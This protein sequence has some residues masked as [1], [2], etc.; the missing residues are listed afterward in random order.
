M[1]RSR[2]AGLLVSSLAVLFGVT[3][4]GKGVTS[5]APPSGI[6]APVPPAGQDERLTDPASSWSP[7]LDVKNGGPALYPLDIGNRWVHEQHLVEVLIPRGGDPQL[8][9]EQR[10]SLVRGIV[11]EEAI[12]GRTYR[13]EQQATLDSA[14]V[15]FSWVRMRQDARG[16]Y[17]A[18][19]AT[20]VPPPCYRTPLDANTHADPVVTA[21]AAFE[22]V[23]ERAGSAATRSA[24]QAAWQRQQLK[25]GAARA[26]LAGG[27]TPESFRRGTRLP[28]EGELL[29]LAAPLRPGGS[30]VVR[31]DPRFASSIEAFESL[32]MPAGRFEGYRIRMDSEFFGPLDRVVTWYGRDGYLRGTYHLVSEARLDSGERVGTVVFD[33]DEVLVRIALVGRSSGGPIPVRR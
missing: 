24:W 11:C 16:L 1:R 5:P 33:F 28:P 22:R 17:E 15:P 32:A 13:V 18:D 9:Y 3:G 25:F 30:W 14:E 7:I 8:L 29:R 31:R 21:R 12:G 23:M 4:C 19:V 6:S 26:L 2:W 20:S 27:I 10:S